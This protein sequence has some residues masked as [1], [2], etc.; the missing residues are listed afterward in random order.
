MKI[1]EGKLHA[2]QQSL[3]AMADDIAERGDARVTG[4]RLLADGSWMVDYFMWDAGAESSR[5]VNLAEA[6]LRLTHRLAG[7]DPPPFK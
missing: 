6:W 7:T 4:V 1:T 3:A 2:A 5:G